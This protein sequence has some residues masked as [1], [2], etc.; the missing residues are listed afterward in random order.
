MRRS[1]VVL[2]LAAT[3]GGCA[4]EGRFT[5]ERQAGELHAPDALAVPAAGTKP[6]PGTNP[7]GGQPGGAAVAYRAGGRRV[8]AADGPT[9]RLFRTG[10]GAW[11]PTIGVTGSGTIFFAARNSNVDPGVARST[12]D[13]RTWTRS[14]P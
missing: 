12:D 7:D 1:V 4:Q 10:Y 2:A 8:S 5:G 3:V 13:G 14:D 11:E 9:G 6:Y